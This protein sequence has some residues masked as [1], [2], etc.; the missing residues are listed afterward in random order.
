ML[1]DSAEYIKSL[2]AEFGFDPEKPITFYKYE[3]LKTD[4]QKDGYNL[5]TEFENGVKQRFNN[6]MKVTEEHIQKSK[7]AIKRAGGRWIVAPG[8]GEALCSTLNRLGISWAVVTEDG[9]AIVFGAKKVIRGMGTWS[10]HKN[11]N[12]MQIVDVELALKTMR[13]S[14]EQMVEIAILCKNDFNAGSTDRL[15]G[16]GFAKA[17]K[18]VVQRH[19]SAEDV[20]LEKIAGPANKK[21]KTKDEGMD[22]ETFWQKLEE[23]VEKYNYG[24]VR[25]LFLDELALTEKDVRPLALDQLPPIPQKKKTGEVKITFT[26]Q[27]WTHMLD[28]EWDISLEQHL[29]L[30][31]LQ[32]KWRNGEVESSDVGKCIIDIVGSSKGTEVL[33]QGLDN[34]TYRVDLPVNSM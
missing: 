30:I 32:A 5:I 15:K 14:P 16:I 22:R 18:D 10:S 2:K 27:F 25:K 13:C 6:L 9:D 31:E 11:S 20:V 28:S 23:D 3:E 26:E 8:E 4:N 24:E 21:R 19:M 12:T 33:K 7:D 1:K 17:F 29:Q 34:K